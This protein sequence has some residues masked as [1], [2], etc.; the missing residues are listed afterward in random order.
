[1]GVTVFGDERSILMKKAVTRSA[2]IETNLFLSHHLFVQSRIRN[3]CPA[4]SVIENF[5]IIKQL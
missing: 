5:K 1:M 2:E 4:D 3:Y